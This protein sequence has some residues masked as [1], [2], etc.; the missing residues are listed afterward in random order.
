MAHYKRG[1]ARIRGGKRGSKPTSNWLNSWPAWHD[2]VFH[3]RPRRR[4]EASVETEVAKGRVDP[5]EAVWPLGNSKP[6][7]YYW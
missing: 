1:R 2:I 7:K 6:H 4:K 5:D 3:T